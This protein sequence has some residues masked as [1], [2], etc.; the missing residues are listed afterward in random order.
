MKSYWQIFRLIF[1]VFS[2]YLLGDAFYRWDGFRYYATLSDFLPSV[3]LITILWSITAA[4]SAL[5]IWLLKSFLRL[6]KL[7]VTAEDLIIFTGCLVLL[8]ILLD[9]NKGLLKLSQMRYSFKLLLIMFLI[10]S[11]SLLTWLFRN[12]SERWIC[13]VNDRVTP[14]VWLFGFCFIFSVLSVAYS[15]L[16]QKP[17]GQG[18][19]KL[20]RP[21]ELSRNRPNIILITFD[22]LTAQDM[23]A[24]GYHRETTPFISKW[25]KTAS[26]F[27]RVKAASNYTTPTTA[28]LMTSK[29]LWTHQ[30]YYVEVAS[31]QVK[32]SA[33]NMP[34]LLMKNGYTNIALQQIYYASVNKLG[35]SNGFE[36]VIGPEKLSHGTSLY[37]YI[38]RALYQAFA[39]KIILYDWITKEDFI[40]LKFLNYITR[41]SSVTEYAPE[42]AFNKF[43]DI[44]DNNLSKPFFAWI[45]VYPPHD[46]YLPPGPYM[47]MFNSSPALRTAKNQ[48]QAGGANESSI[49]I[50]RARYDEFIRYADKEFET[51]IKEL[52]K[53]DPVKT[54]LIILS[55]DHG[56]SFEHNYKGHG[57][58]HLYEQVT[59]IPLIIKEPHQENGQI[60]NDMVEQIDI[61][62][63][64]LG[65]ANIP[66]PIWMEGRSLVPLMRGEAVPAKP[67]FSMSLESNFSGGQKI[68]KGTIAVWEGD[69]KLIHYLDNGKSLLFNL[70]LDPHEQNNIWEQEPE[71][72][73][74]LLN[75]IREN[76]DKANR[77]IVEG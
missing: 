8:V 43:L 37:R 63:T 26:L 41:D 69:Y 6:I 49:E 14:L 65:L 61:P 52:E 10:F 38:D 27:G 16:G 30:T 74:H 66:V 21:A 54:T 57:G 7:K 58:P 33:E 22:A 75:L 1:V 64:I 12:K 77:K 5:V 55:A 71:K 24:Y 45:H 13:T 59:H 25:A 50:L 17:Q 2:L 39:E 48:K 53:R 42:N 60:I 32:E 46:P 36:T 34:Y 68:D 35:I 67:A 51:F 44:I 18:L 28:S 19:S 62:A 20:I 23:S 29:R 11:S 70:D 40:F 76:L 3:A 73:Q 56:E 15:I 31:K 72:G 4:F 9:A 47:G